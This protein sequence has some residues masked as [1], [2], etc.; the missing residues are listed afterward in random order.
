MAE[1]DAID[2]T[3]AFI[4][5]LVISATAFF[6]VLAFYVYVLQ[7]DH[8]ERAK[9]DTKQV[10]EAREAS[11]SLLKKAQDVVEKAETAWQLER[12]RMEVMNRAKER[13]ARTA[14][15][16]ALEVEG[17]VRRVQEATREEERKKAREEAREAV[18]HA[19]SRVRRAQEATREEETRRAKEEETR[20]EM[21]A[22]E[23]ADKRV[24]RAKE[25]TRE[26]ERKKASEAEAKKE[27]QFAERLQKLQDD[28]E[29]AEK[30]IAEQ[31][32]A[33]EKERKAAIE[34][35]MQAKKA[36]EEADERWRAVNK[37]VEEAEKARKEAEERL[38]RGIPPEVRP[39]PEDVQRFRNHYGYTQ[40]K[41]HIAVVGESGMGKSTLLNALSPRDHGHAS[42]GVNETTKFVQRYLDPQEPETVWYDV[43]GPGANTNT[44]GISGWTYFNDYGLFIFDALI[45]T[46]PDHFTGTVGT[47][48]R[49]ASS[50]GV[51]IF[52]VRTKAGQV[53]RNLV[54]DSEE[55]LS[56]TI[57]VAREMVTFS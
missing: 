30:T 40:G 10:R 9:D 25:E 45:V 12:E 42:G 44:P 47:L 48:I 38:L 21:Q 15:E 39:T 19:D 35:L 41:F 55:S 11:E 14:R 28:F 16:A 7:K 46:F 24:R 33:W 54:V 29:K 17:R 50:C 18:E 27:R 13:E 3:K 37:V 23:E 51:P 4:A 36:T 43:P 5:I 8:E 1:I 34:E 6:A 57:P 56:E 22:V 52:L 2:I 31:R 32:A 20:R 49:N 53:L 26:E